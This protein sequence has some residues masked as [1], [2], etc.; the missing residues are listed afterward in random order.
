MI[1]T[2]YLSEVINVD[3]LEIKK[4]NIIKAPTGCG[5]S[6]FALHDIASRCNDTIHQT[7]YLIDTKKLW[8][9]TMYG[10]LDRGYQR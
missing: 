9:C 4:L 6:Y 1:G 3:T 8:C 5:K 7:V 2:K 10:K